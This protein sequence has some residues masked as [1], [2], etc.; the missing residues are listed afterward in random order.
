MPNS[1]CKWAGYENIPPTL[2]PLANLV[3]CL[4]SQAGAYITINIAHWI[5]AA[6]PQKSH[7][8]LDCYS[9]QVLEA[10]QPS[11]PSSN[12]TLALW[13]SI[14]LTRSI[15]WVRPGN[16]AP[17]TPVWDTWLAEAERRVTSDDPDERTWNAKAAWDRMNAERNGVV[18]DG[19]DIN[20]KNH[21]L[22]ERPR[23]ERE[24]V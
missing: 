11:D 18:N 3:L 10:P 16:A 15:A 4:P 6:L 5:A 1:N 7:W 23:T 13:K 24:D 2:P 12:F 8:D 19:H 21:L 20:D 9:V 22:P 14:S 17:L